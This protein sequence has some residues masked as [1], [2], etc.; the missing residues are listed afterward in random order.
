MGEGAVRGERANEKQKGRD[1]VGDGGERKRRKGR[2][3][4]KVIKGGAKINM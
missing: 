4:K 3:R 1:R 2:V